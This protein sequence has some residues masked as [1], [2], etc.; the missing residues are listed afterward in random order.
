[1]SRFIVSRDTDTY[2]ED[3]NEVNDINKVILHR[4]FRRNTVPFPH[5]Y[6]PFPRSCLD[7]TLS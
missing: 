1:M 4:K 2:D 6:H 7:I 5:F 3:W